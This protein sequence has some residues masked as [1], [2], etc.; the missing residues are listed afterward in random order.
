MAK[1]RY[2]ER[3]WAIDVISEINI[4][5]TNKSWHFK[6]AGGESTI[7]N[8][9]NTFARRFDLLISLFISCARVNCFLQ[10]RSQSV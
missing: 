2:N 9:V 5:L 8:E 3:S 10:T 6:S 7:Q 1:V 4:Y